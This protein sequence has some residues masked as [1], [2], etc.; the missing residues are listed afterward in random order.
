[1]IN[2]LHIDYPTLKY[3][4]D[5]TIYSIMNNADSPHLQQAIDTIIEW[6]G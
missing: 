5:T 3:V 2:D 1:M 4:D 6:S